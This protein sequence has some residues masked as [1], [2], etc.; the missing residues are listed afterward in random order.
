LAAFQ[1]GLNF[2]E[3]TELA[4]RLTLLNRF[5][6]YKIDIEL[7]EQVSPRHVSSWKLASAKVA[8]DQ[9]YTAW[10]AATKELTPVRLVSFKSITRKDLRQIGSVGTS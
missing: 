2:Q 5:A 4:N 3:A 6:A 1:K 8:S 10:L 7:S 9:R